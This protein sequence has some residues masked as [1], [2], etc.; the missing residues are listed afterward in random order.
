LGALLCGST[1]VAMSLAAVVFLNMLLSDKKNL[2]QIAF[3]VVLLVV[4]VLALLYAPGLGL[5]DKQQTHGA[6]LD[7]RSASF[8]YVLNSGKGLLFGNGIYYEKY[9]PLPVGINA[10]SSVFYYGVIGLILILAWFLCVPINA[11]KIRRQYLVSI[12]PLLLTA[13]VSQPLIDAPSALLLLYC[14]TYCGADP[15][16]SSESI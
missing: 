1:A 13:L 6:S 8:D 14:T 10:V 7:D 11:V 4:T 9:L 15:D 3:G 5:E 2:A 12:A 16:Y